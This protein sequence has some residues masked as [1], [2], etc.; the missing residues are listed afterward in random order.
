M[1]ILYEDE[2]TFVISHKKY[3]DSVYKDIGYQIQPDLFNIQVPYK[4]PKKQTTANSTSSKGFGVLHDEVRFLE[5]KY[6]KLKEKSVLNMF[7]NES[8]GQSNGE[9][10]KFL[11]SL[12]I[13]KSWLQNTVKNAFGANMAPAMVKTIDGENFLF[14]KNTKFYSKDISEIHEH[15]NTKY[16]LVLLDPPWWNKFIRRKRKV[17]GDGYQML[18]NSDIKNIPIENILAENGIVVVWCTNSTQHFECLTKD[19]FPKWQVTYRGK[20]FWLKVAANGVPVCQF[21]EPPRKQPFEKIIFGF[22]KPPEQFPSK[23]IVS[24]PSIMDSHKPPLLEVLKPYLPENAECLEIFARYLLP[25][26]TSYGN[27][28]LKLQH[29]YIYEKKSII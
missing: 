19:I 27:E 14:P 20:W 25:A 1:S 24:V 18:Y 26:W 16:N 12:H 5:E 15:L 2:D 11:K 13:H 29:E 9:A 7:C 21:S 22:K 6:A 17:T 10:I 3:I 28:V 23:I 4:L 8:K